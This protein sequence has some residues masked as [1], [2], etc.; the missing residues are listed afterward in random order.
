M[1]NSAMASDDSLR[2]Q[3]CQIEQSLGVC[4]VAEVQEWQKVNPKKDSVE[5][6]MGSALVGSF[7]RPKESPEPFGPK[8]LKEPP[9]QIGESHLGVAP[10]PLDGD[11]MTK[12]DAAVDQL[13]K[14]SVRR[15]TNPESIIELGPADGDRASGGSGSG[16]VLK[17]APRLPQQLAEIRQQLRQL[18]ADCDRLQALS[19]E[20]EEDEA[21]ENVEAE[22]ANTMCQANQLL[23][24]L[25]DCENATEWWPKMETSIVI[26]RQ[27]SA[28]LQHKQNSL[29]KSSLR[30]RVRLLLTHSIMLEVS[31]EIVVGKELSLMLSSTCSSSNITDWRRYFVRDPKEGNHEEIEGIELS[32]HS[33]LRDLID[34]Y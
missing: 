18:S 8:V 20:A 33:L 19:N 30:L 24:A 1:S 17:V 27:F 12:L 26:L 15:F 34:N 2:D 11:L 9:M 6:P 13:I 29:E 31:C 14:G 16:S 21:I 10:P 22:H 4:H 32:A 28:K 25:H 5:I 7:R 23:D 3:L